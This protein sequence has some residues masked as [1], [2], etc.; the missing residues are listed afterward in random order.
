LDHRTV[1]R[2]V[3]PEEEAMIKKR[4]KGLKRVGIEAG[5]SAEELKVGK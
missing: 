4:G 2:F 1:H 5:P 3:K